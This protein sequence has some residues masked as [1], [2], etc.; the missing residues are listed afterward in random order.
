M[1]FTLVLLTMVRGWLPRTE[2]LDRCKRVVDG[3]GVAPVSLKYDGAV[4]T[5]E[6]RGEHRYRVAK[7][8]DDARQVEHT[9]DRIIGKYI[10]LGDD[11]SRGVFYDGRCG[12]IHDRHVKSPFVNR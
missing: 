11:C 5:R 6:R 9:G 1:G 10:A 7:L 8:V 3:V 2:A 4:G 12:I